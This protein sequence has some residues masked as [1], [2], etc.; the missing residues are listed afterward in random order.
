V[1]WLVVILLAAATAAAML[2][3][4]PALWAPVAATI[5][6]A[7]AGYA[8]VGSAAMPS[9]PAP[10]RAIDH[11]A[12]TAFD[13]SRRKLL[14][15]YGDV[16]AWLTFSDALSRQGR[17]A[18]AVEGLRVAVKAMPD[19]P[20]LWVGLGNAL[21]VHSE[22]MITPAARLAFDRAS[23]LA[24]DHPAP[25]YFLGLAWLQAAEPEEAIKIWEELRADSPPDAP[26]VADL[27]RKLRGARAMQ[28]AGV[29][30]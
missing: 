8:V 6:L 14:E 12:T 5:G 25:R 20:D 13:D 7:A 1:T 4:R 9:K 28:A 24:P 22:G 15:N 21:S 11:R 26:W 17:S 30:R 29:G 23:Q 3:Y 16:G 19:S 10:T 18:D 2:R 27:E